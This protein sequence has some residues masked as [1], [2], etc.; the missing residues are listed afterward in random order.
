MY[1]YRRTGSDSVGRVEREPAPYK[2][3]YR[4]L[5][6]TV[7]NYHSNSNNYINSIISC[8]FLRSVRRGCNKSSYVVAVPCQWHGPEYASI[9]RPMLT[10]GMSRTLTGTDSAPTR[11]YSNRYGS[12]EQLNYKSPYNTV[13]SSGYS[14]GTLPRSNANFPRAGSVGITMRESPMRDT[15]TYRDYTPTSSYTS[16]TA[17]RY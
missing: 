13:S 12:T 6:E 14:S 10:R 9:S 8:Q 1:S 16:N 17:S 4:A 15:R 11:S 5:R 7:D 3:S 2:P